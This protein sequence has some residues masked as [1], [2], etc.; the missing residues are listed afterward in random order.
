MDSG[1]QLQPDASASQRLL[2]EPSRRPDGPRRAPTGSDSTR[3]E[4]TLDAEGKVLRHEEAIAAGFGVL[5][6]VAR[7][8][9]LTA[10]RREVRASR[11]EVSFL[12]LADFVYIAI[13]RL[14]VFFQRNLVLLEPK[15]RD[16]AGRSR[17]LV[18]ACVE[19]DLT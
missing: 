5:D 19:G 16:L 10:R 3:A 2:D 8:E 13:V 11:S 15:K 14:F 7:Y 18:L 9:L 4:L 17:Q 12:C 1:T 6:A